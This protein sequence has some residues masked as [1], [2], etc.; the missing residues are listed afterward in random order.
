MRIKIKGEGEPEL[1]VVACMHGDEKCGQEAIERFLE[2]DLEL[3]KPVKFIIANEK[4]MEKDKRFLDTDL[5]R[6]FPG[7]SESKLHEAQLAKQLYEELEGMKS[8]TLHSMENFEELFCL[9][10]GAEEDLVK[11]V[12][13]GKAVDVRPLGEDSIEKYLDAVTVE[14]GEK[15]TEEA[16]ENAFEVMVEFMSYF[17]ALDGEVPQKDLELFEMYET[18]EG[19]YRFLAENFKKVQEGEMYAENG[20]EGLKAEEDFYPI[21]MSDDGYDG[22]LGFKGRKLENPFKIKSEQVDS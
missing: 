7:N 22:I 17:G 4:A 16:A 11:S 10:N 9:V 18:V 1:A 21:L 14:C 3:E 8:L 12:G 6:C 13:V 15:G 2:T 5:N 20:S 19:E